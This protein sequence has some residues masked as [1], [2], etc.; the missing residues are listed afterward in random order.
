MAGQ[1]RVGHKR[2]ALA[3][4]VVDHSQH[5]EPSPV[6]QRIADE[7][8]APADVGRVRQQHRPTR[9]EDALAAHLELCLALEAPE[10][11]EV[12]HDPLSFEHDVDASVAEAPPLCRDGLHRRPRLGVVRPDAA[13]AHAR[14]IHGQGLAR[15][16]LAHPLCRNDVGLLL[17]EPRNSA[18]ALF[19][20]SL[21]VAASPLLR[22]CRPALSRLL[23]CQTLGRLGPAL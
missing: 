12:H 8:E 6:R 14:A 11:L 7:V 18:A 15:P 13:I 19:S 4:E 9:A 23:L 20:S 10:L 1:R 3:A 17:P 22:P 16:A 5:S 21:G 2:Q